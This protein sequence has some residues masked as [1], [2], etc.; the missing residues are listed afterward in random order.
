MISTTPWNF[1]VRWF[2]N[3]SACSMHLNN[4]SNIHH[5][6]Y[7]MQE[8]KKCMQCKVHNGQEHNLKKLYVLCWRQHLIHKSYKTVLVQK[9]KINQ[10]HQPWMCQK[11]SHTGKTNKGDPVS[12]HNPK[13][14]FFL[15]SSGVNQ[16]NQRM[17]WNILVKA[18]GLLITFCAKALWNTRKISAFFSAQAH[19]YPFSLFP[20]TLGFTLSSI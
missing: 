2:L 13:L 4:A 20:T 19:H 9:L 7:V 1:M 12:V 3:T 15:F 11:I 8:K 16:N 18:W 10:P 14:L 17:E 5:F 6:K